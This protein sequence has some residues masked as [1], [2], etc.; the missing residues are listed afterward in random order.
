MLTLLSEK[1]STPDYGV[2]NSSIKETFTAIDRF[3]WQAIDEILQ[4][5]EEQIYREVG[6]KTFEE[7]CQRELYAWGGYRRINQLL[8]AKKVI[9]AVG[10]LGEH[11]KNERQARPLLHLVKEPEK[12]KT[13]VAIAL[14]ENPSPSESDFAAAAQKVVPQLPRKKVHEPMVPQNTEVKVTSISHPRYPEAVYERYR[15]RYGWKKQNKM[16]RKKLHFYCVLTVKTDPPMVLRRPYRR[17]GSTYQKR[18][19]FF[20]LSISPVGLSQS[21]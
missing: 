11:I 17:Q 21:Q 3:E 20:V 16:H 10:E 5:R 14:K 19:G 9:D 4:M 15:F 18:A 13:A 6:Y 8:G 12:L 1:T 2:L 7:Y